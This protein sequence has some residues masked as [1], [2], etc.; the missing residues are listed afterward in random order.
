MKKLSHILTLFAALAVMSLISCQKD[1]VAKQEANDNFYPRIFDTKNA[2][3]NPS[4]IINEGDTAKYTGISYSPATKVAIAWKVNDMVVS[5]DTSFYFK[6][7]GGGDY[8]VVLE[9]T[10]NGQLTSRTSHVLVNPS[11][12]TP[13]PYDKISLAYL[14]PDATKFDLNW[15]AVTHVA[16]KAGQVMPDGTLDVSKGEVNNHTTE[17]VAKAHINGTPVLLGIS[18]RLSGI[19]GWA[20][21]EVNDFG[22]VISDPAKMP[23][24]VTAVKNY[25]VSKR[26]D[27]VDIMMTDINSSLY[28]ANMQA[29]KPFM[30]ALRNALPTQSII[31]V[32]VGANWTHWSYPD[33]SGAD[34]VNLHAFEDGVHVGPAAPRGQASGYDFMVN[35]ATIF[36]NFHLPASKIVVG[37]PAFGLR[38]DAIDGDG[39]NASWGSYSYITYKDILG[40]DP[41]ANTKEMVNSAYGIYYN[42]VPLVQQKAT[43]I[44]TNAFKGAYLWAED[45]DGP[46]GAS[47]LMEAISSKLK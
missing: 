17:L 44:K 41:Q 42:G 35:C 11:T 4:M 21:Y 23:G 33:L 10:Y 15:N 19:D 26:L 32:T 47:S 39:N 22:G 34:W 6:P 20:L 37:M 8:T 9:V 38:Y 18:G 45:F 46:T 25:V 12:Y 31:T 14:S 43:Y 29:I 13:K 36:T 28:D 30:E 1:D 16:F 40:I 7:S 2:F 27:G 3:L 24:L 5:N